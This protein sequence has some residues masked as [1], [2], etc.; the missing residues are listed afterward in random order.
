MEPPS[1][2]RR[3]S[4]KSKAATYSRLRIRYRKS[5][6]N[7]R[8]ISAASNVS[9]GSGLD[10]YP[11]LLK[12]L[13][14]ALE[15]YQACRGKLEKEFSAG[16]ISSD[17]LIN[18]SRKTNDKIDN[19]CK[20]IVRLE[21]YRYRVEKAHL[22]EDAKNMQELLAE[23]V[24]RYL[25]KDTT[26][27]KKLN[28]TVQYQFR[29]ALIHD[30]S[31][32][33][34]EAN[35]LLWCAISGGYGS[36]KEIR[37]AHI[38]PSAFSAE[39]IDYICG[40]G[41]GSRLY[42]SDNGL[43]LG[44]HLEEALDKGNIVI[45]PKDINEDPITTFV[46]RLVNQSSKNQPIYLFEN[47]NGMRHILSDV[48]GRELTFLNDNRPKKRFL[49][50][51]YLLSMMHNKLNRPLHAGTTIDE[52]RH[53][54]PWP[55][56]GGYLRKAFL[57]RFAQEVGDADEA[58][59]SEILEKL[60]ASGDLEQENRSESIAVMFKVREVVKQGAVKQDEDEDEDEENESVAWVTKDE[61]ENNAS[62]MEDFSQEVMDMDSSDE[63][64]E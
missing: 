31:A 55:T 3:T 32:Q 4:S 63:E 25:Y 17:D 48:D 6:Q 13:R 2:P 54:Y 14:E 28:K 21:R 11:V 37:A 46:V 33:H 41:C 34:P 26:V 52:I 30:N 38:V 49:Y 61:D 9:N 27:Q 42:S 35:D 57:L 50:F 58:N 64:E 16:K 39:I 23:T 51:R 8:K 62:F 19:K 12:H 18:G 1:I 60:E 7:L 5:K 24:T 36:A 44:N 56:M 15:Y 29:R 43:L 20:Q 45:V 47:G 22:I 10:S 40:V 59:V 53:N